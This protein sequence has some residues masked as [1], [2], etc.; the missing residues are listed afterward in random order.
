M[1]LF[2][3]LFDNKR[4]KKKINF[5]KIKWVDENTKI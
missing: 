5:Q 2:R 1:G 4:E 3:V